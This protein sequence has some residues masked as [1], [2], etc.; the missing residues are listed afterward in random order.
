MNEEVDYYKNK[1]LKDI[2][3][4]N[5]VFSAAKKLLIIIV[6]VFIISFAI[7][8]FYDM[9]FNS[10]MAS[11]GRESTAQC[12]GLGGS[13]CDSDCRLP[14]SFLVGLV[15]GFSIGL[16]YFIAPILVI[17]LIIFYIKGKSDNKKYDEYMKS[18]ESK[19]VETL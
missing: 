17:L 14:G 10:C 9:S 19:L 15:L 4:D 13:F 2:K 7:N 18:K 3:T 16:C 5:D 1:L 8:L 6:I 11:K 12:G